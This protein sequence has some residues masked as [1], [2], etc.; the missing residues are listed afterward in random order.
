MVEQQDF[1]TI[2]ENLN[3]L[4]EVYPSAHINTS[5]EI[6][7]TATKVGALAK[8]SIIVHGKIIGTGHKLR[9]QE[10]DLDGGFVGW[11]ET[12]SITRAI[13]IALKDLGN[14][15]TVAT[16]EEMQEAADRLRKRIAR[17]YKHEENFN[18][19]LS[20]VNKMLKDENNSFLKGIVKKEMQSYKTIQSN[21]INLKK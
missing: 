14:N 4:R 1:K 17:M 8:A 12:T 9:F 15:E 18:S 19:F 11:A 6:V 20:K 10:D 16:A 13:T 7:K 2:Q 3:L 21:Q 5:V